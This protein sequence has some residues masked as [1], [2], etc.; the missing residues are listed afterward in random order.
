MSLI[1][2]KNQPSHWGAFDHFFND[3]F[4]GEFNPGKITRTASVPAANIIEKENGYHV[5]LAAPGMT[6]NDFKIELNED[7]LTIR[8]EKSENKEEKNERFTKREF[9]YTSF[10]RSFR[11]PENVDVEKI[12]A[13]YE[14]G[15]L[16]LEIPKT[17]V[18]E[19][20]KV[21]QI[22]IA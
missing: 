8:T 21:R 10:V 13:R 2:F 9:N 14:N 16:Q 11:I 5:E 20:S 19:T 4:E 22:E 1:K 6:K 7:L 3:F 17:E 15:I 18:E 12:N